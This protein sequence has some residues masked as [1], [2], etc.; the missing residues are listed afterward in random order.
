MNPLLEIDDRNFQEAV[1]LQLI[2]KDKQ[3]ADVIND[4]ARDVAFNAIRFCK[5]ATAESIESLPQQPSSK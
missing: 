1:K 5:G 2:A 4:M 3:M